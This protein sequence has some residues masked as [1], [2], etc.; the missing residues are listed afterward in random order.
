MPGGGRGGDP[1]DQAR[2]FTV[3]PGKTVTISGLTIA[4]G[5]ASGFPPIDEQFGGGIDNH[6]ATLTVSNCFLFGNFA[7]E[8]GG[9]IYNDDQRSVTARLAA[10]WPTNSAA[11]SLTTAP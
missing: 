11:A 3:N 8:R 1:F 7:D 2:I 10:T 9:G 4:S 5:Y 6:Q